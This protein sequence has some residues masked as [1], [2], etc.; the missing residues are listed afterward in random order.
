MSFEGYREFICS[1]GHYWT[2]DVY[3]DSPKACPRCGK[4]VAHAHTV[5]E[6]NGHDENLPGSWPMKKRV[7]GY[8]DEWRHDRH[9][10]R[11]AHTI[12]LFAPEKD[13]KG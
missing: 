2:R 13:P 5:D 7:I 3:D 6:T 9:G 8:E 11:Y 12:E 1:G 4:P 10:N